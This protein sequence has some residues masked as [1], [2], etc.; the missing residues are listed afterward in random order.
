MLPS[1]LNNENTFKSSIMEIDSKAY[2]YEF[3][4]YLTTVDTSRGNG[5]II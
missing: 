1:K 4:A 2:N 3:S 5:A